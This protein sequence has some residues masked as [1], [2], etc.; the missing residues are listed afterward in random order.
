MKPID[1]R[2]ELQSGIIY[3]NVSHLGLVFSAFIAIFVNQ[4]YCVVCVSSSETY[5]FACLVDFFSNCSRYTRYDCGIIVEGSDS[6]HVQN[7]PLTLSHL[8]SCETGFKDGDLFMSYKSM[9][10]DVR[11]GVDWVH[12]KVAFY[13]KQTK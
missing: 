5:L 8:C 12:F 3:T 1:L 10:Q 4:P 2:I 6:K 9:F 11:D 13:F 7:S